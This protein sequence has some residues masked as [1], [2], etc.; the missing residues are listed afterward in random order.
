MSSTI[1]DCTTNICL[2]I[3]DYSG[4]NNDNTITMDV[5]MQ[6]VTDDEDENDDSNLHVITT[7]EEGEWAMVGNSSSSSAS[8]TCSSSSSSPFWGAECELLV[9]TS[10]INGGAPSCDTNSSTDLE[11]PSTMILANRVDPEDK[12][13]KDDT[14][15]VAAAVS[16]ITTRPHGLQNLGNTCYFNAALQMLFSLQFFPKELI[17]LLDYY[18]N[19]HKDS[20]YPTPQPKPYKVH[21]ITPQTTEDTIITVPEPTNSSPTASSELPSSAAT[22]TAT[23]NNGLN[24]PLMRALTDLLSHLRN[25]TTTTITA[26]TCNQQQPA[27]NPEK[28]KNQIDTVTD[29]FHGYRQQDAHEFL[30]T[31]LD[32]LQDEILH[33]SKQNYSPHVQGNKETTIKS[34]NPLL[35]LLQDNGNNPKENDMGNMIM[36]VNNTANVECIESEVIPPQTG[37]DSAMGDVTAMEDEDKDYVY[38]TNQPANTVTEVDEELPQPQ[39]IIPPTQQFHMEITVNLTCESCQYTRS[40][41]ELYNHLSFEVLPKNTT[42]ALKDALVKFFSKEVVDVS[43]ERCE[44]KKAIQTLELKK[45]PR[46]LLIHWNRFTIDFTTDNPKVQKNS[47][48]VEFQEYL[49]LSSLIMGDDTTNTYRLKSVV[50]HIGSSADCGHYITDAL[51]IHQQQQQQQ[52]RQRQRKKKQWYRFNDSVVAPITWRDVL[53]SSTTNGSAYMLL[54]EL[55]ETSKVSAKH[56]GG[57]KYLSAPRW[58]T[59]KAY[60]TTMVVA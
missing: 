30:I 44:C 1:M 11:E 42:T 40:H 29:L 6:P 9:E 2:P 3:M 59:S 25:P 41:V 4:N 18:N 53:G 8:S 13:L 38:I 19:N 26:A 51:H 55:E 52:R 16:A 15:A 50:H 14:G 43:C 10:S 17:Y 56:K 24:L 60:R 5:A 22:T 48:P 35:N 49:S 57:W 12:E 27:V 34:T 39:L 58:W 31:L 21:I 7:V 47:S 45:A 32:L 36:V 37:I 28:L 46:A 33:F 54:Y 20:Y 23:P